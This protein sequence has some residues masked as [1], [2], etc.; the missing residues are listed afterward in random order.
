MGGRKPTRMNRIF[1]VFSYQSYSVIQ[2]SGLCVLSRYFVTYYYAFTISQPFTEWVKVLYLMK[3]WSNF[4]EFSSFTHY[5]RFTTVVKEVESM[6]VPETIFI[7]EREHLVETLQKIPLIAY[8]TWSR[9]TSRGFIAK[10]GFHDASSIDLDV[11]VLQ[12][13]YPSVIAETVGAHMAGESHKDGVYHMIMAPFISV[14]SA[15]QC[16]KMHVGHMDMSG[17]YKMYVHSLYMSE[18]GHQNKFVAKRSAKTIFDP[19]SQVS[20]KILRE[21]MCDVNFQWKLSLLSEKLACSIGQVFKV[22]KYLCERLWAEMTADGLKILDAQ[23]IMRTWSESYSNKTIA[24]EI[25]NCYTLFSV[26]D[27]EEKVRQIQAIHGIDSY[28]TGFAGGVRYTP[29][30]RYTKV[31]LL[32]HEKDVKEFL[33]ASECKPVDSGA[34]V[35]IRVIKSDELLYDSRELNGYHAA[36]P[37]QVYLDCANLKECGQ[38]FAEAILA[39]EIEK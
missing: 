8:C 9:D 18:L 20:S 22:K 12:R 6:K 19:S 32:M 27:F 11:I 39:K 33:L 13:A 2:V 17:N 37:V 15:M 35:Q 5:H 38:E 26:P 36:S 23:A 25:L 24:S 1:S 34:N 14:E 28:L 3:V 30:V 7:K 29:I 16:E 10:L 21:L 4:L 31:H